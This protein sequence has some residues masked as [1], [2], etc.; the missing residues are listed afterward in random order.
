MS[1]FSMLRTNRTN[2]NDEIIIFSSKNSKIEFQ[3]SAGFAYLNDFL[4]NSSIFNWFSNWNN[5]F[6]VKRNRL[7]A[8]FDENQS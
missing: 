2:I 7:S 1:E 8:F 5:I 3:S 6:Q 4:E